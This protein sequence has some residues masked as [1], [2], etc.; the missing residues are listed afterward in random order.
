MVVAEARDSIGPCQV[1]LRLS[2][3]RDSQVVVSE[4]CR[5]MRLVVAFEEWLGPDDVSPFCEAHSPPLVVLRDRVILGQV[6]GQ[7]AHPS[8]EAGWFGR[9]TR[10]ILHA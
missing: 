6:E 10:S 7:R 8:G 2:S 3:L 5:Q 4:I 9:A 1:R